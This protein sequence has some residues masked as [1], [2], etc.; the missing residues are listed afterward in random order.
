MAGTA[1]E[2]GSR[3]HISGLGF[4]P[5]K[6]YRGEGQLSGHISGNRFLLSVKSDGPFDQDNRFVQISYSA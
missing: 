6:S 5:L 3:L 4:E 2:N 1:D